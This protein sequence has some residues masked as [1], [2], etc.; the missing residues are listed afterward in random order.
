VKRYLIAAAALFI[1]GSAVAQVPPDIAAGIR[2]IGPV[3]DSPGTAKLYMPLFRDVKEP[4]AAV[5]VKRDIAYGPDP[6]NRLDVFA[7]NVPASG[8][9]RMVVIYAHGGRFQAG[10]KRQPGTIFYDNLMLF[11]NQHGM[12]GV[13]MDYRLAPK[14]HWPDAQMDMAAV[15][16]WVKA[17]IGAYGGDP[18]NIV[19]WGQSAGAGLVAGYLSHPE[20][21]ATD[22]P[23]VKA[24]VMLSGSYDVGQGSPYFGNDP[25]ELRERSSVQ[26]MTKVTIPLFIS[27]TEVDVPNAIRQAEKLKGV[28]CDAGR[29]PT[30]AVFKDHSHMSQVFSVGTPDVS[31]SGPVLKFLTSVQSRPDGR[32]G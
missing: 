6:L 17:N 18:G 11:L 3:V 22:G 21:H 8:G 25:Q 32:K 29:C 19:L 27:H 31:V 28:L 4:Y 30:Y 5:T 14:N 9:G 26:G 13:N 10:D 2:K 15:V 1:A 12:I 23:G 7:P 20:F 16:R 24:A